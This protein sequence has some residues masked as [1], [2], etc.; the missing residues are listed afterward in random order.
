MRLSSWVAIGLAAAAL[1]CPPQPYTDTGSEGGEGG[2][3]ELT[4]EDFLAATEEAYCGWALRCGGGVDEATC[5]EQLHFDLWY[6]SGLL[7]SGDFFTP[8][9]P[10][11]RTKYL[12][13]SHEAGRITFD[14]E[15]AAAC[16][17]WV[18][19]RGCDR[20]GTVAAGEDEVAGRAAC[21]G[22]LR[23][24]VQNY[25]PCM[26]SFEC[27]REEG[28]S[29]VCGFD[30]NCAEMCCEG[31]CRVTSPRPIGTPCSGGGPP[32]E[33]GSY[34]RNDPMTG[35]ATVCTAAEPIGA[36]CVFGNE[37]GEDAYCD[38]NNFE[39]FVCRA[40][41]PVGADCSGGE[42]ADGSYCGYVEP[43]GLRCL[44]YADE[45]EP[46]ASWQGCRRLDNFCDAQTGRCTRPVGLGAYCDYDDRHCGPGLYCES[47]TVTCQTRA[48]EG[49]RC[50]YG[51]EDGVWVSRPC[52][53][54]LECVGTGELASS[55]C[56]VPQAGAVCPVP[57]E[58]P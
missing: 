22:A 19:A 31:A 37:C 40:R 36:S 41:L 32:C 28:E 58:T 3:G 34:C 42:C 55:A 11:V 25:W 16:L 45:G 13:D 8:G 44:A 48:P 29:A 17:A 21:A 5:D 51:E 46:C 57:E 35:L 52:V 27:A 9:S 49:E 33:R 7:E 30:P 14:P 10:A 53:G 18:D 12:T 4:L 2:D 38:F 24:S 26:T 6:R 23:G 15:R 43:Q 54:D 20:P 50:G 39:E 1:G 56:A 47:G